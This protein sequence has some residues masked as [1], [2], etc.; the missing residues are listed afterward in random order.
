MRI[1]KLCCKR[2][3]P[4]VLID[5]KRDT[6]YYDCLY[7]PSLLSQVGIALLPS[8]ALSL[9]LSLCHLLPSPTFFQPLLFDP[10]PPSEL[11]V[12]L[13]LSPSL[14]LS[15]SLSLYLFLPLSL[16]LSLSLSLALSP[17]SL[18]FTL[19]LSLLY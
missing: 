8:L 13:S 18:S 3:K 15:H 4:G 19:S 12:S 17:L 1:I 14:T 10:L 9:S 6:G 2:E 5:A 11:S 16:S 7:Y